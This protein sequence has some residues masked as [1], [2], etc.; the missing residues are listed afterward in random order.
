MAPTRICH[1]HVLGRLLDAAV[2]ENNCKSPVVDDFQ[3][4]TWVAQIS[5]MLIVRP[6]QG[7]LGLEVTHDRNR[8]L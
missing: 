3:D 6:V 2:H 7:Y 4:C 5:H 1:R 8:F